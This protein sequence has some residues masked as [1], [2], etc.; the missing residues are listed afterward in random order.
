MKRAR[1]DEAAS[2]AARRA[3]EAERLKRQ[4][5]VST[6][7]AAAAADADADA[8]PKQVLG[9]ECGGRLFRAY[10][11][12]WTLVPDSVLAIMV[13]GVAPAAAPATVD[14]FV[15]EPVAAFE[16][17]V[18]YLMSRGQI[19]EPPACDRELDVYA[20]TARRL[21][22]QKLAASLELEQLRRRCEK[23]ALYVD[24]QL[25]RVRR[26]LDA[27][28]KAAESRG[29]DVDLTTT[30]SFCH[31][32]ELACGLRM[33]RLALQ[34]VLS[35][36]PTSHRRRSTL[37]TGN[38]SEVML[39]QD[40]HTF[41][42]AYHLPGLKMTTHT[43]GGMPLDRYTPRPVE[44]KYGVGSYEHNPEGQ[45]AGKSGAPGG[46]D[47]ATDALDH[48]DDVWTSD[49]YAGTAE[50]VA[51][52]SNNAIHAEFD[53]LLFDMGKSE[54]VNHDGLRKPTRAMR[55]NTNPELYDPNPNPPLPIENFYVRSIQDGGPVGGPAPNA[56]PARFEPCSL[57][58]S[59]SDAF[60]DSDAS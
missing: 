1:E 38:D 10:R 25:E 6:A 30:V 47:F 54:R 21:G 4:R 50:V 9:I 27:A 32:G 17:V 59:D 11:E 45:L 22:L 34:G 52:R 60:P 13:A 16:K 44:L 46:G 35:R 24:M 53:R 58:F 33:R 14:A 23:E 42:S 29:N 12:T 49:N 48:G 3:A 20:L 56:A 28:A 26:C 31:A 15:Q 36:M 57:A 2:A 55:F 37:V 39:F 18:E 8:H 19:D 7:E 40:L 5:V 43:E 51:H 41:R